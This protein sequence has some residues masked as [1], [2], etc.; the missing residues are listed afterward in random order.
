MVFDK[1]FSNE[2]QSREGE[3]SLV[4]LP[5]RSTFI[6]LSL[7]VLILVASCRETGAGASNAAIRSPEISAGVFL[8]DPGYPGICYGGYRQ[9]TRDVQPTIDEIKEDLRILAAMGIKVLRTYNTEKPFAANVVEAIHQLKREDPSFEMYVMLGT[10]ITC[11]IS[12][13]GESD[14]LQ[15][16]SLANRAEIDRSVA[17]AKQYPDIV[18]IIAVG[19]EAMVHWQTR[20]FVE[21]HVILGWVDHLQSLKRAG[22]LPKDLWITSSDNFASWGG[23]SKDYHKPALNELIKAVDFVSMH[24]Y[25]MHD[26]HYNPDFWGIREDEQTLSDSIKVQLAMQRAVDYARSQYDSTV[27]YVTS[28]DP[29][30]PVHIGETGWAS[31]SNEFYG[32]EGSMAAD[33]YKSGIYYQLIRD[34]TAQRGITCFYFEAFDEIWKDAGNPGGSENHFGLFDIQGN[35]KFP[36]WEVVDRGAFKEAGRDG[37]TI[38]KTL[39]GNRDSLMRTVKLPPVNVNLTSEE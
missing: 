30:K 14:H 32:P 23:G 19:N 31:A 2:T 24:T 9:D 17:I 6:G 12:N 10:W 20:Y 26:T 1:I 21:P 39:N 18:K 34:W 38:R 22:E 28:V 37:G 35:A 15:E 33:E 16:D 27:A 29:I 36:L 4:G 25:P 11:I 7:V 13:N 5:P 8:G 3:G